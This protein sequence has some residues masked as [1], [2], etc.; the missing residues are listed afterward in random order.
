[1]QKLFYP[2]SLFSLS[3]PLVAATFIPMEKSGFANS[4]DTSLSDYSFNYSI[5]KRVHLTEESAILYQEIGLAEYGLSPE[6]FSYA[7]TGY[8][9]LL[10]NNKIS[11][12]G[13]LTICDF[14]QSSVKKRLYV[15][16]MENNALL[17]NT[18]VAHGRNS[19][20]EYAK[21]F[22]NKLRSLQS[23]IGFFITR[24]TYSGKYGLSL[25]LDG[26]E[27]GINNNALRRRIV[28]HGSNYVGEQ[29]LQ[30][31]K[32]MGRS[33]GCPAVPKKESNE[34]INIIKDE[35]CFFIYFPK[36]EYFKKSKIF[37]D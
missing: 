28:L 18:Y 29:Y 7:Y 12:T 2:L 33:F 37:N 1:M 26:I 32:I 16:D 11:N 36:K 8:Q 13:Y 6:A 9:N 3:I 15:I 20:L 5:T 17:I 10:E 35:S 22:S 27:E 23:S 25:N 19:G 21:T 31:S 24:G 14:S 4:T 34:I 30:R